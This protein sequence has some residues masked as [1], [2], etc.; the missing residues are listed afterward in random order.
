MSKFFSLLTIASIAI[1][2][3]SAQAPT[4]NLVDGACVTNYDASVDYFPQKLNT[5][6]DKGTFFSVSYHNHYKVVENHKSGR[7]YALVQCGTPAPTGLNVTEIYTIPVNKVAA[8]ETTAVPYLELLGVAET[9]KVIADGSLISSP[10]FQT[11]LSSGEVANLSA[12]NKTLQAEQIA[13]VQ[14]QF[15]INPYEPISNTTVSTGQT[16]EPDV[17]G[18]ASWIS[19]YAAFY[20]Y[21]NMANDISNKMISNY[22]RLTAAASGYGSKPIVAWTTF[23]APSQYNNNTA[24]YILSNASYKVGL[25]R[26]AGAIMLES[27]QSVYSSAA[28]L[29]EAISSVDVLIDETFIGSDLTDFLKNYEIGSGQADKYKFLKNKNVY[30]EDGILTASGG[31]DWFEAPVAMADALLED[32]INAVN[33]AAPSANYKRNWLRNIVLDEPIKYTTGDNCTWDESS[34]RPN[35]ATTYEGGQFTSATSGASALS[36]SLIGA[37]VVSLASLAYAA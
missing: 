30:R 8:M 14:A 9:I 27:P 23:D 28:E 31:Y 5:A 11:Y 37:F 25:T 12:N 33:P 20:N 16:Y 13:S 6:D 36:G 34:P 4:S 29:L 1:A 32:M 10:C 22:Q 24:S 18:R 21:E 35:L 2:S 3:V 19:Y 26:D 7:K 15:G 17:L